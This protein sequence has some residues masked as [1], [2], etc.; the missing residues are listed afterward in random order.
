[1]VGC[2]VDE[3]ILIGAWSIRQ[4]RVYSLRNLHIVITI[5]TQDILHKVSLALNIYAVGR[6]GY[7]KY[8]ALL[9]L[10]FHLQRLKDSTHGC[11]GNLLADKRVYAVQ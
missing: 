8:A 4:G 11:L 1:M 7:G 9:L 6:N 10:D 5:D 2:D 3:L